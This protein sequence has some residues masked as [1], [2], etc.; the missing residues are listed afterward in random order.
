MFTL[1]DQEL[2][3]IGLIN[4]IAI[5]KRNKD[6][7]GFIF[8]KEI[9]PEDVMNYCNYLSYANYG[10][11]LRDFD[12][13][14]LR[15]LFESKPNF[16]CKKENGKYAIVMEDYKEILS[17]CEPDKYFKALRK[18]LIKEFLPDLNYPR[19][20]LKLLRLCE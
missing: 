12:I 3:V 17:G 7:Y 20:F 2:A 18:V 11:I 15:M 5:T 8:N 13:N 16:F 4:A 9:T 1:L 10:L 6:P 14:T 19:S